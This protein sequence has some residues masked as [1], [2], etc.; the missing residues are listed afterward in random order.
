M[1][2]IFDRYYRGTNTENSKGTG[3]GMAIARDIIKAHGAEVEL[4]SRVNQGTI[5]K[6]R[7]ESSHE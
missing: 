5:V 7:Y 6:I 1:E 4:S 2:H 3:L